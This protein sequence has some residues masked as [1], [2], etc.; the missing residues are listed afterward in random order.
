[1]RVISNRMGKILERWSELRSRGEKALV[2][3]LTAGDPSLVELPQVLQLLAE[4][5]ADLLEVGMPFSDPIADGPTIQAASHR[6]LVR[7]TTPPQVFGMLRESDVEIPMVMMGYLNP[8]LRAGLENFA[9]EARGA[10]LDGVIVCDVVPEEAAEW[11]QAATRSGL[12]TIF[13]AAPTSTDERLDSVCQASSGFVY[14]VSRTGVTGAESKASS[15]AKDLVA[16][17]RKRTN[18]PVFVGF[19]ISQPEQVREICAFADGVVV[20]SSLV[21]MI[22]VEWGS[23]AGRR[24]ISEYVSS[25]K[26]ATR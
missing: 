25:L 10:G 16:R 20:G 9:A 5:G 23:E 1:M 6:S 22:A 17:I 3:Y 26:E 11:R 15:G 7:G 4:S 13:L 2:L 18:L 24:R 12:D 19:G 21:E 14:A 8:M